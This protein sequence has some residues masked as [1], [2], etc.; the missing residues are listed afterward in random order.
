MHHE[1]NSVFK[2]LTHPLDQDPSWE[3]FPHPKIEKNKCV[4]KLS[5]GK[6]E[7]FKPMFFG[8]VFS[9]PLVE[10][11]TLFLVEIRAL[12]IPPPVIAFPAA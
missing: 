4:L 7:C 9:R 12:L 10:N 11:S 6:I 2:C 3:G 1:T 8:F 5:S